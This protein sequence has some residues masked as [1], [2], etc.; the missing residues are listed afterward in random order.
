MPKYISILFLTSILFI[1]RASS[2]GSSFLRNENE[3]PGENEARNLGMMMMSS[4]SRKTRNNMGK[5]RKIH[6][7]VT[8]LSFQQ[9]FS[10]VFV[11]THNA[12]AP[13]LFTP[14]E[15]SSEALA[16]LAENGKL[17]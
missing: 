13:P 14:G 1:V 10:G 11:M 9:P 5:Q 16:L 4:K 12:M 17:F 2:T 8:N 7:K 3:N 6:L 15:T